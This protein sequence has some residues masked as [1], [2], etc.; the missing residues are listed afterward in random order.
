MSLKRTGWRV[1]I[2]SGK[3]GV[4]KTSVTV[5]LATALAAQ[6]LR[7]GVVDAD[8]ALGNVDV[9]LG[10]SPKW[11][12]GHVISGARQLDEVILDGPGGIKFAPAGSGVR[13]L[14]SLNQEQWVRLAAAI[15]EFASRVDLLLID[16]ATGIADTVLDVVALADCAL[17][18]TTFDPAALVDA[19]ALVKLVD[20]LGETPEIGV[21]VN[22][23]RNRADADI[24]FRQLS[25][26]S[27]RFLGRTLRDGGAIAL[28]PAPQMAARRTAV[29]NEDAQ[30]ASSRRG[31][32]EL[33]KRL[34][35]WAP[36]TQ[37]ARNRVRPPSA[38][39]L[40]AR[41]LPEASSCA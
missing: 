8:L 4:G 27:E 31:Y 6:G 22:A 29:F 15:D 3:G 13:S 5:H 10:L 25:M 36:K 38:A 41:L 23:S 11:H 34:T 17:V 14:T 9:L 19:Y 16:T 20:A 26:V 33:A 30:S 1:A 2:T 12:L 40:A 7:V 35:A 39:E 28:D 18:V 21:L 32:Q 37:P 24:A